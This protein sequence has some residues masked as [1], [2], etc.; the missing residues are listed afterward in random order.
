MT[1]ESVTASSR[2]GRWAW[3][4]IE[5]VV[6]VGSSGPGRLTET[7]CPVINFY[8][9]SDH[10]LAYKTAHA[11]DGVVLALSDAVEAGAIVFG[12]L[13]RSQSARPDARQ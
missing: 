11:L 7:C 9:C 2:A 6:F 8:T 4:P 5:A 10:A 12:D 3:Q 13:L 1:G